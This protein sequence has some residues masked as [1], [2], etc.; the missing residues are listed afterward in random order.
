[1]DALFYLAML[2]LS[3]PLLLFAVLIAV[4]QT[5]SDP[6]R[7]GATLFIVALTVFW[8]LMGWPIPRKD[9]RR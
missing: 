7:L 1:M 6:F 3:L 8:K 4:G 5:V 9:R 2:V